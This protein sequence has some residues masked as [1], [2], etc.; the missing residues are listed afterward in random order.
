MTEV[1]IDVCAVLV[2]AGAAGLGS[3][4][5]ERGLDQQAMNA[6]MTYAK[7]LLHFLKKPSESGTE[8]IDTL[9]D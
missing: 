2:S 5:N 6:L 8:A 4:I 1:F 3:F 7:T 9:D